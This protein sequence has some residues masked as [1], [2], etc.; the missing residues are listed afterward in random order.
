ME[1]QPIKYDIEKL[2]WQQF[3][4]LSFKCLQIDVSSSLTFIEGGRD[5]GRDFIFKGKTAFWGY[6][7]QEY[8]FVFQA[9]HKSK[10]DSFSSLNKDLKTELEKVFITNKLSYNFY[11]LVTNLTLTG[12]HYD[13]LDGTFNSFVT[14]NKL[15]K[16]IKFKIYS[17][18]NIEACIDK[19]DFLK[20]SFP[21]IVKNSDFKFLL[22]N[23]IQRCEKNISSGWL[24]VFEKNKVDFIYTSIFEKALT[25]LDENNILLLSG[26]SK[27]GKTFN[28]EMLLFNYFCNN[29]FIPYKI[30]TINEFDKF[31]DVN[32]KQIFLFDDAFGKYNI[33]ISRADSFNRKLEYIFEQVDENHKCIFTSREYI[34]KAFQDYLN[35][36]EALIK[37][38]ITKITVEVNDLV[39][40]EKESIFLRY[41]AAIPNSRQHLRK[42][43]LD[44][45]LNHKNFSP[46]TIRAYFVNNTNFDLSNFIKHI[47][48]PDEYLEKDFINLSEDKKVVLISTLL[49]L[50][51]TVNSIS[52]SYDRICSDL[53]KC[54]LISLNEVLTHL[55]GS[56]LKSEEDQYNF[57]HP[58]MF[59]F[60]VRYIA[61]DTSIYR[62]LLLRNF[63]IKLLN[64]ICFS[65][66]NDK[67]TI[68]INKYDLDQLIEGFRR[69]IDNPELSIIDLN[70]IFSWLNN[71]DVQVNLKFQSKNDFIWIKSQINAFVMSLDFSK[72]IYE[73]IYHLGD[74]FKNIILNNTEIKIKTEFFE[75]TLEIHKNENDYWLLVFRM[76]PLL[77]KD[78]IFKKITRDWFTV[79]F[80]DIKKEI[81]SLGVELYGDAYPLF[82]EVKRY[83]KLIEEGC[84]ED[85]QKLSK[86]KRSDFRRQTN[87][88]WYPRYLRV[89][90]KMNVLKASQ[91]YGYLLYQK[92]VDNF[93]HLQALEENQYNRYIFNKEKKW[94]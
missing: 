74:F 45:I 47:E 93:S 83:N 67:D 65:S 75:N 66:A 9:K 77:E 52:I 48:A 89:K 19:N 58:S 8:S 84:F 37:N 79:F 64:A 28:A 3:E 88:D 56:I 16:E 22:E 27:S 20:W 71:P 33:D 59:E 69:I 31:Y 86:N 51:N 30:D 54:Y 7:N 87:K 18:R 90:E 92:L 40:D 2:E 63:N 25:K 53:S 23:I 73:N 61:K 49:S 68:K 72:F 4:I 6:N 94:W 29:L 17:Y 14:E 57:Y 43:I 10:Q 41:S 1:I 44:K 81:N 60:F 55:D 24:S 62:K 50:K 26:P 5:K 11:C 91:P 35:Y 38:F 76:I 46:E 12:N 21:S 78:F 85:A 82:E 13:I 15:S 36:S 42:D 70:S 34:Y 80:S 39:K 32:K